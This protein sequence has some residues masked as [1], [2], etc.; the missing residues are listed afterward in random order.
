LIRSVQLQQV[1]DD[2][3]KFTSEVRVLSE[4]INSIVDFVTD[5]HIT[6]ANDFLVLQQNLK[7]DLAKAFKFF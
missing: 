6:R 2:K 5:I 7:H 3:E 4:G 1:E